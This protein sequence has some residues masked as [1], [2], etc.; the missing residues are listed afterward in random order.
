M[1]NENAVALLRELMGEIALANGAA[2]T[3]R[4]S[5]LREVDAKVREGR[6][7]FSS[8]QDL[9]S[10]FMADMSADDDFQAQS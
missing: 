8:M 10:S 3:D 2:A 1:S 7:I 5:G 4:F 9:P 6:H